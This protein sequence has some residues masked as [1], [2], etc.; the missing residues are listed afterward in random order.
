MRLYTPRPLE[1]GASLNQIT[2]RVGTNDRT[3]DISPQ[4]TARW[5][6][7][8]TSRFGVAVSGAYSQ[9]ETE[10]Q[11]Y[12][13]YRWRRLTGGNT[14][15]SALDPV[16]AQRIAEGEIAFARGNRLS[17]WG[18]EQSRFGVV[19]TLQWQVN[20]SV[21][22]VVDL[23]HGQ[24]DSDRQ[25][26][27]LA[28]RGL[29]STW[30][31]GD[32]RVDGQPVGP[33]RLLE[34]DVDANGDAVYLVADQATTASET[35]I[36]RSRHRMDQLSFGLDWD[37][38]G[39]G[40]VRASGGWQTSSYDLP[41]SDKF[42]LEALGPVTTDY[43]ADRFYGRNT[44]GWDVDRV[45]NWRAHEVDR[46]RFY[47]DLEQHTA[48][49]DVQ[50]PWH[51][52]LDVHTGLAWQRYAN[53][54]RRDRLDDLF[55]DVFESGALDDDPT[56]YARRLDRHADQAWTVV[57]QNAT[58]ERYG[59]EDIPIPVDQVWRL[60]EETL[61]AY[62]QA[63][64]RSQPS[65]GEIR[66]EA[67][68]RY[69]RTRTQTRVGLTG[70]D[71]NTGES[72]DWL[73]SLEVATEFDGGLVI[74]MAAYRNIN[75]PPVD[76]LAAAV[77]VEQMPDNSYRI[78]AGNPDLR[79][80]QSD[81]LDVS[82]EWYPSGTELVS[83]AVFFKQIDGFIGT[84]VQTD[85]SFAETGLDPALAPALTAQSRVAE[86]TRSINLE[87]A[88]LMGLELAWQSELDFLPG[89]PEPFGFLANLTFAEGEVNYASPDQ[90]AR[91]ETAIFGLE[92]LSDLTWNA[93]VYYE[94][95]DWGVRVSANHRSD[96]VSRGGATGS[97]EDHRG[98][99]ATTYVDLAAFAY[100]GT[101]WRWSLDVINLTDE[102]EEQYSDSVRRLYNATTSGV[103]VYTGLTR[104]F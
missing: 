70:Q 99:N 9:R 71:R 104:Q 74:R 32:T 41:K 89:L 83:A 90:R 16:L 11:G 15:L 82:L 21:Q 22:A 42:Y 45:Q 27:H 4:L 5:V 96:Y 6:W 28:S 49:L 67:G 19:T 101:D 55:V 52:G 103:T 94:T 29:G 51:D 26:W 75:R 35:R 44:Y 92:G 87:D 23:M 8:P 102:R 81:N 59:V 58:F 86:F 85:L 31:D 47:R 48:R 66:G 7:Q 40:V 73:P 25:E 1:V 61:S 84:Q 17:V 77:D 64:F 53:S 72:S 68:V 57:D 20:P 13:T 79:P 65:W 30:L 38:S 93:S 91:G 62:L 36:Q 46:N 18:A 54:G 3:E 97:D 78:S 95:S 12:N 56:L 39:G 88:D 34:L 50:Q 24:F 2:A 100:L 80:F 76:A 43:R 98:F 37:L 60:R 10:E 63:A 69:S 33:T 14:D